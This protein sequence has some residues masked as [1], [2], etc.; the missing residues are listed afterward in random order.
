MATLPLVSII[1]PVYNGSNFLEQSIVSA[2]S[3]TYKNL[4]IIVVND[5]STDNTEEIVFRYLDKVRYFSKENGGVSSALNVGISHMKGEFF[6]WLSH[7][8]LYAVNKISRQIQETQKYP[9][10][11]LLWSDF[12]VIDSSNK[13]IESFR[14]F[15]ENK[16][17]SV[18]QIL[19]AYIHGCSLLI[20]KHG[21]DAVGLFN[22]S[23]KTVQ[24]NEL[25]IRFIKAG[26]SFMHLQES[27]VFSRRHPCQGQKTMSLL[28]K[29][30]CKVFYKWAMNYLGG[31]LN[32]TEIDMQSILMKKGLKFEL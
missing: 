27:L 2:L 26:Y 14:L 24:D 22:E 17:S 9:P 21:F 23:L 11:T 6:S 30:E 8:D 1:I 13:V 15:E 28:H 7:D 4:E 18:F 29:E 25:W 16:K 12:D 32:L 3:Q 31:D 10:K 19:S 20:P 5:G